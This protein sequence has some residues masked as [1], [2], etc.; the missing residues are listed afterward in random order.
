MAD[1]LDIVSIG[2]NHKSRIIVRV[3]VLTQTGF[4]VIASACSKCRLI[5]AIDFGTRA[6]RKSHMQHACK[7]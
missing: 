4:T 1:S 6:C 7:L 3:I 5:E 2:I